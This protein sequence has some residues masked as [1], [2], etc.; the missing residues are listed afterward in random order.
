MVHYATAAAQALT[1]AQEVAGKATMHA[2]A[3]DV[4]E[5]FPEAK[6]LDL[7]S[8]DQGDWLTIRRIEDEAGADLDEGYEFDD[9]WSSCLYTDVWKLREVYA[10][11][12]VRGEIEYFDSMGLR[13]FR[14]DIDKVLAE[15]VPD[16][17]VGP[18]PCNAYYTDGPHS[19][20]ICG[21]PSDHWPAPHSWEKEV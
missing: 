15:L 11:Y 4:R 17:P 14:M 12:D 3:V 18:P 9:Q 13:S 19:S 16:Q 20:D 7:E 10:E 2:L 5:A 21:L 6:V 8:S 1:E